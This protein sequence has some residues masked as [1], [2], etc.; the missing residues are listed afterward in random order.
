MSNEKS[1]ILNTY[2]FLNKRLS[3]IRKSTTR[4]KINII[5]L[6]SRSNLTILKKKIDWRK[7][8]FFL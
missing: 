6:L 2:N 7:D 5:A 8:I 1:R 3:K 4:T